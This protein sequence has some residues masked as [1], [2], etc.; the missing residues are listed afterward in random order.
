MPSSR[1]PDATDPDWKLLHNGKALSPS[2]MNPEIQSFTICQRKTDDAAEDLGRSLA[3][4]TRRM[5][6]KYPMLRGELTLIVP[7]KGGAQELWALQGARPVSDDFF[8]QEDWTHE[9]DFTGMG[10]LSVPACLDLVQKKMAPRTAKP[11]DTKTQ[12]KTQ[13]PLFQVRLFWLPEDCFCLLVGV[14]H[15]I[16]D[17]STYYRL[18]D[19]LVTNAT[20]TNMEDGSPTAAARTPLHWNNAAL[21]THEYAEGEKDA[22]ALAGSEAFVV[23]ILRNLL[24][25]LFY[26]RGSNLIVLDKK[27]IHEKKLSMK[28]ETSAYLSSNDIILAALAQANANRQMCSVVRNDRKRMAHL[29]PHDAGNYLSFLVY[30]TSQG[31]NP[32]EL[33][34]IA[35]AGSYFEK[36]TIPTSHLYSMSM[37]VVSSWATAQ[38][39]YAVHP[40]GCSTLLCHL[41]HPAFVQGLPLDVAVIF[42]ASPDHLAVA[43]N[44]YSSYWTTESTA[45]ME[46]ISVT[47]SA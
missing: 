5:I 26:P 14:S 43:H 4:A 8:V 28:D 45:L 18:V 22:A 2:L 46:S 36:D 13:A 27:A 33:R 38:D 19:E 6:E 9:S 39:D 10:S 32:N 11:L 12:A 30:P 23:G 31:Q 35:T 47:S 42:A 20:T 1:L 15:A 40:K 7:K 29:E 41:P 37:M 3:Q 44:F 24:V 17:G 25:Q 21:P 16:A 34:R